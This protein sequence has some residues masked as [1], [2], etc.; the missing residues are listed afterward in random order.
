MTH[1]RDD[2]GKEIGAWTKGITELDMVY[3]LDPTF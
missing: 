3:A 2:F 1:F